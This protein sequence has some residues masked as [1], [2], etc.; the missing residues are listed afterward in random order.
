MIKYVL[1]DIKAAI[2]KLFSIVLIVSYF[3]HMWKQSLITPMHKCRDR[4]DPA[5]LRDT[6]QQ[7]PGKTVQQNA[8]QENTPLSHTA[9]CP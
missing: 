7:Q 3:P 5:N 9:H 6:C 8:E 4:Y 2:A 1:P